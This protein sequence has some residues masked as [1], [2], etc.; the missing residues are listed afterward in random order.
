MV[1][2]FETNKSRH[3]IQLWLRPA[4]Q[5]PGTLKLCQNC[6][7]DS[8]IVMEC[9]RGI[10]CHVFAVVFFYHW[11][12]IWLIDLG[13]LSPLEGGKENRRRAVVLWL[14]QFEIWFG[15]CNVMFESNHVSPLVFPT[16]SNFVGC[17]QT[18]SAEGI[19]EPALE[20][21][22]QSFWLGADHLQ[23]GN[24]VASGLLQLTAN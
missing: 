21:H 5:A 7:N 14:N 8:L 3:S 23:A 20:H 4:Q 6:A 16:V 19:S 2:C 15:K 24:R 13:D 10:A 9:L 1:I 12:L 18:L 11:L 17:Y 22:Q